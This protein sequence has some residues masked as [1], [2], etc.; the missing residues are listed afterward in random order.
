M[1]ASEL[2]K[3]IFA[4]RIQGKPAGIYSVCSANPHVLRAAMEQSLEDGTSVLIEATANQVNQFGGYTGMKPEDFVTFVYGIADECGFPKER[5]VLG[6]DHLGPLTW[7]NKPEDEAM[8]LAEELVEQYVS[9]GF[10]KIHLD[11]SMRLL[12]D[13]HSK[14]LKD[15]VVAARGA[16]LCT[17]AEKAYTERASAQTEALPPI[18]VI[19]SEVPTPGGMQEVEDTVTPTSKDEFLASYNSFEK[20]FN[21]LGLQQA[22]E[23][24]VAFVVQPG[25]EFSGDT[26]F[27]YDRDAAAKLCAALDEVNKDI[28][29]E[30]HST[31]YQL[32]TSLKKMVEDGIAILKVGPALTFGLREGLVALEQFEKTMLPGTGLTPSNF[33]EALEAAMLENPKNWQSQYEGTPEQ[34]RFQRL[35]SYY[36]RARYYLP[37]EDVGKAIDTLLSNLNKTGIPLNLIS[38]YLP[39]S[40]NLIREGRLEN[41]PESLL[42]D[43]VRR[44]LRHYSYACNSVD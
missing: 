3:N 40:Y 8:T 5:I 34:Q 13:D 31:D 30:G 11:T 22:F 15:E 39:N 26:V 19:G 27:D 12:D 41:N 4:Q 33:S 25:V 44:Y 6:G 18:Y 20:A 43:S 37:V 2:M 10:E 28:I 38:Q 17:I 29:F 1:S 16:R 7:Q 24:V 21:N 36:D 32:A 23:R 14:A 35:Y 9:A 42:R